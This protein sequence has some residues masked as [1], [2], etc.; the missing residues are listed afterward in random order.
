MAQA[1]R[2]VEERSF[3][4]VF[5]K[6]GN[7]SVCVLLKECSSAELPTRGLLPFK[8]FEYTPDR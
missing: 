8:S 3:P 6:C 4:A 7:L 1:A 2:P 5:F